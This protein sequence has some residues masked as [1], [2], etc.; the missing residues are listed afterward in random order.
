M[1]AGRRFMPKLSECGNHMVTTICNIRT[2]KVESTMCRKFPEKCTQ[3]LARST[4]FP[5][6]MVAVGQEIMS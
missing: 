3:G 6:D 1:M 2:E 4:V 5:S